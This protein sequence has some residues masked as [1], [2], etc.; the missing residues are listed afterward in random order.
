MMT[1]KWPCHGS[2]GR[3][4][5]SHRKDPVRYQVSPREEGYTKWY[6]ADFSVSTS[7][8]FCQ[9]SFFTFCSSSF[10]LSSEGRTMGLL[11]TAYPEATVSPPS[12]YFNNWQ[13]GWAM[14]GK[15][16]LKNNIILESHLLIDYPPPLIKNPNRFR[17]G[18]I[19]LF[20]QRPSTLAWEAIPASC[21]MGTKGST[22]LCWETGTWRYNSTLQTLLTLRR[23]MSYIYGAPILDVSRSHT[24]T[25]HSR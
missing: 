16:K 11:E 23:L 25:Q 2:R 15:G 10:M 3:P 19:Y 5:N 18:Q 4:S 21:L 13:Y 6:G 9:F 22:R 7:V 14:P 17:E 24:T 12:I 8:L 1:K 20:P